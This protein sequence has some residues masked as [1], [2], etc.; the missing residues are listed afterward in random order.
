M[1]STVK[2]AAGFGN[3]S[4]EESAALQAQEDLFISK[5]ADLLI[6]NNDIDIDL[7]DKYNVKLGLRNKNGTGVCVGLTH[8]ANVHGYEKDEE[9][10]KVRIS[11]P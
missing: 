8:I 1:L 9:G 4:A 2:P 5:R 11:F 6:T 7:Y 3:V 10:N